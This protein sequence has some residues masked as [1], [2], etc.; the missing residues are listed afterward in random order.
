VTFFHKYAPEYN[1]YMTPERLLNRYLFK[2]LNVYSTS[3]YHHLLF[4]N[5][6]QVEIGDRWGMMMINQLNQSCNSKELHECV[7]K[8]YW[9]DIKIKRNIELNRVKPPRPSK[10]TFQLFHIW[11]NKTSVDLYHGAVMNSIAF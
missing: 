8:P 7:I 6:D 11:L 5:E 1:Y 9:L 4:V 3:H 10:S 2:N